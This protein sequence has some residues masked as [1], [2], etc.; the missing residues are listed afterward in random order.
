MAARK[1]YSGARA[2][3]FGIDV[4][5]TYSGL[6]YSILEPGQVPVIRPITRFPGQQD[7]GGDSKVPTSIYYDRDGI[8]RAEGADTTLAASMEKADDE[9]WQ[10]AHWFKL[11]LR[12]PVVDG[13][14]DIPPLP[15]RKTAVNVFGD[16][17]R[18]LFDRFVIAHPNGWEGK[19]QSQMR[20]AAVMAG[21]IPESDAGE[22]LRFVTEGEASLHF[23]IQN[24]LATEAINSGKGVVVVDAGGGTIDLSTYRLV[25]KSNGHKEYEEIAPPHCLFQGSIYVTQRARDY[26]EVLL[27]NSK[28]A[29]DVDY[30]AQ[31]FDTSAKLSFRGE[32]FAFI[33][34]GTNRD[35]DPS[36]NI[37][38]GQLKIPGSDVKK[39][40]EPS[41]AA[42]VNAVRQQ[43]ISAYSVT[44]V[45]SVFLVGG[46]AANDWLFSEIKSRLQPLKLDVTRPDAHLNKAVADGAV[47]FYVDHYVSVRVARFTYGMQISEP[48]NPN[49][50][51]HATR[52]ILKRGIQVCETKEFRE[53]YT[54]HNADPTGLDRFSTE[55]YAYRGR[56]DPQW[57]DVDPDLYQVVCTIQADTSR[58]TKYPNYRRG[59]SASIV[60]NSMFYELK[61]DVV[62][63]FGLTELKAQIAWMENASH[64]IFIF[65]PLF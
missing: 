36:V 1:P 12:P 33:K 45:S 27:R 3:V 17:L 4:G 32:E 53:S 51:E 58:L 31:A 40:F 54:R 13:T 63:S 55:L 16:F 43:C 11:H 56:G 42:V 9:G 5:T 59:A 15:Y 37:R 10:H 6:S 19:Q 8:I 23:C 50:V 41:I 64:F 7:V 34:F 49:N 48:Y 28:Y 65:S 39:L 60:P 46:F 35:Q 25:T 61:F 47:S 22:R 18:Y 29:A 2:L 44:Q 21:L 14:T 52:T 30:I 57:L 62:L 26:V 24:G 38:N 20:E